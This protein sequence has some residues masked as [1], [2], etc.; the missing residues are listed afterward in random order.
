MKLKDI[1]NDAF[2][3]FLE[4]TIVNGKGK[5][6]KVIHTDI[7][8][9]TSWDVSMFAAH[10]TPA[11]DRANGERY[12]VSI[13]S[14]TDTPKGTYVKPAVIKAGANKEQIVAKKQVA[15]DKASVTKI[16]EEIR[17]NVNTYIA[18]HGKKPRTAPGGGSG[19]WAFEIDGKTVFVKGSYSQASKEAQKIA[20]EKGVYSIKVL[21]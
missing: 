7:N 11:D 17:V 14:G 4:I 5:T 16:K 8:K 2:V 15:Q 18:S 19:N 20:K 3:K 9:T 10:L 13:S 21:P 6:I 12:S 1:M